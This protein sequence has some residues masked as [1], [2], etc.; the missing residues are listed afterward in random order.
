MS[1][2]SNATPKAFPAAKKTPPLP[3]TAREF[4]ALERLGTRGRFFGTAALLFLLLFLR[5]PGALLNAQFWAEDGTLFLKE[6]L[7][8]GFWRSALTPYSDYL[9]LIPRLTATLGSVVPAAWVPLAFNLV[10]LLIAAICC[11]L[12]VL[13][14]YR[15]I[16]KSDS[17]RFVICLLM[18]C[19]PYADEITGNITDIQVYLG[20]A[21]I[22]ITFQP[23]SGAPPRLIGAILI[24][25]AGALIGLSCALPIVLIPF[26][27][28]KLLRCRSTHR[29]WLGLMT[30]GVAVQLASILANHS[31]SS[32]ATADQVVTSTA[33]SFVYRAVFYQIGGAPLAS[34]VLDH[35]F[36]GVVL[37]TLVAVTAWFTWFYYS[38]DT[39]SRRTFLVYLYLLVISIGM[40]MA[41]R[42]FLRKYYLTIL[43]AEPRSERYFFLPACILFLLA[44]LS[45]RKLW[46]TAHP[47][48]AAVLLCAPFSFGLL[49]NFRIQPYEDMHWREKAPKIDAWKKAWNTGKPA[50]RVFAVVYPGRPWGV[51]LPTRL[52]ASTK[53]SPWEG[54]LVGV[55][56]KPDIYFIDKG[57]K[58]LIQDLN[59]IYGRGLHWG[60]DLVY[61]SAGD[62]RRIPPGAPAANCP[63]APNPQPDPAS[64]SPAAI[65][66][67]PSSGVGVKVSFTAVYSQSAGFD[68]LNFMQL[69]LPGNDGT[70]KN[71][72]WAY[73]KPDSNSLWL[74][75]DGQNGALG[76]LTPGGQGSVENSQCVLYASGSSVSGSGNNLTIIY[77][78]SFKQ[79]FAGNRN[80]FLYDRD[81]VWHDT[82]WQLR[83]AWTVPSGKN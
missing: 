1:T 38:S 77:A 55:R 7:V 39:R 70:G 6:Q 68:Q 51:T 80:V 65:S 81:L 8:Y 61:L 21:A 71:A 9:N 36:G 11:S 22:L 62:L 5:R 49:N 13:P 33:V 10:A 50:Q 18:A 53:D 74:T 12:F 78:L 20:I 42:D 72:C 52:T 56:G 28:W 14:A 17:Q 25:L 37:L 30:A 29:I 45:I 32:R 83:G 16:L 82:G 27:L 46:P 41:G 23:T 60:S 73:Y 24:G 67:T 35:G 48:V 54:L 44:A 34:W 69:Y 63:A 26:L 59:C 3:K 19:A 2:I 47:L 79:A 76:P 31:N 4:P 64:G 57:N 15:F 40:T 75:K 66:V 43:S 58:H